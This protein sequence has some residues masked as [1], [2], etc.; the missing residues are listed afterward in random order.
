MKEYQSKHETD[1]D[2]HIYSVAKKAIDNLKIHS[3]LDLGLS[4][5]R[6]HL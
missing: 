2:P 1:C 3:T 6:S 4:M 5:T